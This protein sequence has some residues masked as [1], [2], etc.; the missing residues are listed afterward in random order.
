MVI[1]HKGKHVRVSEIAVGELRFCVV[2]RASRLL[3]ENW[4]DFC[5]WCVCGQPSHSPRRIQ[6]W[7]RSPS[8]PAASTRFDHSL[9]QIF[10]YPFGLSFSPC[11]LPRCWY[12]YRAWRYTFRRRVNRRYRVYFGKLNCNRDARRSL[13]LDCKVDSEPTAVKKKVRKG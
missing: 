11:V 8:T 3:C 5:R 4:L 6:R 7:I 13:A 1:C 2:T 10:R 12:E 9:T